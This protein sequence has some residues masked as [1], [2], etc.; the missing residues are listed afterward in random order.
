MFAAHK[1][2]DNLCV[3]IDCNGLQ[4]D[5]TVAEVGG[6]EPL[7]KKLE[8]FGFEVFKMD[9]HDF[10][11]IEEAVKSAKNVSGKPQA[12]IAKTVKGKGVSYMENKVNWHGAAPNAELYEVGRKE[13]LE[14]LAEL[15]GTL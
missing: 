14:S 2:L 9:G 11:S 8:A 6:L 4:I 3:I 12:I 13:L 5:G 15:G 1:N 7:D 10:N